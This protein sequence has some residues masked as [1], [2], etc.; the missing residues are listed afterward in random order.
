MLVTAL[1][2]DA[3]GSIDGIDPGQWR[4]LNS[5]LC[6]HGSDGAESADH[7]V[8]EELGGILATG[9]PV[10][11]ERRDGGG[12]LVV[13]SATEWAGE[14]RGVGALGVEVGVGALL[15]D[16]HRAAHSRDLLPDGL[17]CHGGRCRREERHNWNR[18]REI[19]RWRWLCAAIQKVV[20]NFDQE[21]AWRHHVDQE[22]GLAA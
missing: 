19:R 6:A 3:E 11:L 21:V 12:V 5:S 20:R 7:E 10:L 14:C 1:I 9:V 13:A 8:L 2:S 16:R 4:T 15:H 18:P 17:P 22:V